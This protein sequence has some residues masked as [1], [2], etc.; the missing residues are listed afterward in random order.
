MF[1]FSGGVSFNF[2]IYF[3]FAGFPFSP[4]FGKIQLVNKL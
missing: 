2:Q 1:F 4:G 3:F